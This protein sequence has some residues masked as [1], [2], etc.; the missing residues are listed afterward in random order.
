MVAELG[1]V[2]V[3]ADFN[4]FDLGGPFAG[5]EYVVYVIA[6]F[7]AVPKIMSGASFLALG[8]GKEMVIGADQ[9]M[10]L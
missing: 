5:K 2:R 1:P 7:F 10:F 3:V 8:L 9:L 4:A 6:A